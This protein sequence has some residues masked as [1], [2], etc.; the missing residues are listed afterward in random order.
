MISFGL[1]PWLKRA[2]DVALEVGRALVKYEPPPAA[3]DLTDVDET[4]GWTP[5]TLAEYRAESD[6]RAMAIV[7]T[8]MQTILHRQVRPRWANNRYSPLHWRG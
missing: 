1:P 8:R 3:D 5:E 4:N 7:A 6:A 2:K